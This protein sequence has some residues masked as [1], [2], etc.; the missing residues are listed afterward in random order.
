MLY[1]DD[2]WIDYNEW[3][4]AN[5]TSYDPYAFI[6]K[7]R[8]GELRSFLDLNPHLGNRSHYSWH[9][10]R[11]LKSKLANESIDNF[12]KNINFLNSK[13]TFFEKEHLLHFNLLLNKEI[14]KRELASIQKEYDE[15]IIQ[16]NKESLDLNSFDQYHKM[17][18][19]SN[20]DFVL[21][22]LSKQR[23]YRLQLYLNLRQK[24]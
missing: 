4:L 10:L 1:M 12:E 11:L 22:Y 5:S 13:K 15:H 6:A 24:K 7:E 23:N 17:V 18:I 9:P 20:K 8:N 3:D 2:W 16:F 14:L 21:N 19:R